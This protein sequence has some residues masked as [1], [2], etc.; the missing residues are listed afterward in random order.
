MSFVAFMNGSDKRQLPGDAIAK[1]VR[2]AVNASRAKRAP[3][4][5][6]KAPKPAKTV[7]KKKGGK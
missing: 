7:A 4:Y 3:W 6:A 2:A 1:D 5:T